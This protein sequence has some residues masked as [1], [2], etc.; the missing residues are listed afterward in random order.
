MLIDKALNRGYVLSPLRGTSP[1]PGGA[2]LLLALRQG[3]A[4]RGPSP[5]GGRGNDRMAY[6]HS[7]GQG[8]GC[9]LGPARG[10]PPA[11]AVFSFARKRQSGQSGAARPEGQPSERPRGLAQPQ[12]KRARRLPRRDARR[13]SSA[14]PRPAV[15]SSPARGAAASSRLPLVREGCAATVEA[16]TSLALDVSV[17]GPPA[18]TMFRWRGRRNPGPRLETGL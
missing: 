1:P 5:G 8:R 9:A 7:S 17:T 11:V 14:V 6:E 4:I 18:V 13:T 2:G 15:L 12:A 16:R 10:L 3:Q